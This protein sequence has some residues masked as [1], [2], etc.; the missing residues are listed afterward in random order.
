MYQ[1]A[2]LNVVSNTTAE[3]LMSEN[4]MFSA[5]RNWSHLLRHVLHTD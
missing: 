3:A 5:V 2:E 4:F 1:V